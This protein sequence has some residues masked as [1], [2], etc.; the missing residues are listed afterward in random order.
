M[1][2]TP[3]TDLGAMPKD[4]QYREIVKG[5]QMEI[6]QIVKLLASNTRDAGMDWIQ[7]RL[8]GG[9]PCFQLM[10]D[11]YLCGRA[12][13]WEGHPEMHEYV[14]LRDLLAALLTDR[15]SLQQALKQCGG[16][17]MR[18]SAWV[19]SSPLRAHCNAVLDIPL[20]R[21]AMTQQEKAA[22]DSGDSF[23]SRNA[24]KSDPDAGG[25]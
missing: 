24:A 5:E 3:F 16:A 7:V 15:D 25:K 11:G 12:Q 17:L 1:I 9:P 19:E 10:P 2:T 20:V 13:R 21:E 22:T 18:A 6:E 14:S 4:F 8:N 23:R